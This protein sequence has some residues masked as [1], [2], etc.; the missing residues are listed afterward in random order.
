MSRVHS[1]AAK[2]WKVQVSHKPTL[3]LV[4]KPSPQT[5][6]LLLQG[7]GHPDCPEL[8]VAF[9]AM[10]GVATALR[11]A[12]ERVGRIG[13]DL[14]RI[15]QSCELNHDDDTWYWRVQ[16]QVP[17]SIT[18]SALELAKHLSKQRNAFTAPICL[19]PVEGF[20]LH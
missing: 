13:E 2:S 3:T 20:T 4:P 11:T 17:H 6:C 16:V 18:H 1:S 5:R 12:M 9:E 8:Y 15:E 10:E 19:V 7:I 14:G